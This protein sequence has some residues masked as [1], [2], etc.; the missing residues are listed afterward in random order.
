MVEKMDAQVGRLMQFLKSSELDDRTLV[1][2]T[3]DNGTAGRSKL[4]AI[5]H[6]NKFVY[7]SVR[8]EFK[9]RSI[10]GGKGKLT[11]WGTRVPTIAV[12]KGVI[13]PGQVWDDL[14]DFSDFLPTLTDLTGGEYPTN[15]SLDGLSFASRLRGKSGSAREWAYAE[16]RGRFFLKTHEWK[17]YDSGKFFHTKADPNERSPLDTSNLS[18]EANSEWQRLKLA[19]DELTKNTAPR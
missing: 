18:A 3:T 7:E 1:L 15:V 12:W 16:H 13:E 9:G 2:F 4:S 8:S 19:M 6:Q 5:N 17:L 11:D 10:P 14:V